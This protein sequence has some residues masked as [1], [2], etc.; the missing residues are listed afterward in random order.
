MRS[1]SA[2]ELKLLSRSHTLELVVLSVLSILQCSALFDL[3]F[4]AEPKEG[5]N[6]LTVGGSDGS[7]WWRANL[8]CRG[9]GASDK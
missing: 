1:Y 9:Q 3:L 7:D 2:E 5:R 4:C 6:C 8:A